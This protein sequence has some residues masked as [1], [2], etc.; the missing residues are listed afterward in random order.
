VIEIQLPA[1]RLL[2]AILAGMI[3]AMKD[4]LAAEFHFLLGQPVKAS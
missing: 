1:I 2:A 3:I 4:V